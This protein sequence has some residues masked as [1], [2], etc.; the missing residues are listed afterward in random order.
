MVT[1]ETMATTNQ[2]VGWRENEVQTPTD[3]LWNPPVHIYIHDRTLRYLFASLIFLLLLRR[4]ELFC[5]AKI[6]YNMTISSL[7]LCAQRGPVQDVWVHAR[8]RLHMRLQSSV[9]PAVQDVSSTSGAKVQARKRKTSK[10]FSALP[11]RMVL[12]GGRFA[13]PLP[14]W[15]GGLEMHVAGESKDV[16]C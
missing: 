8:F 6:W 5:R 12:E 9:V 13:E 10:D 11:K 4:S 14:S 16:S 3:P 1:K 7:R 15:D 2:K